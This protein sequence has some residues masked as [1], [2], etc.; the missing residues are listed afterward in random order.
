[1]SKLHDDPTRTTA[2]GMAR[3]GYEFLGAAFAVDNS[4]GNKNG[5][6]VITPIP[7][8]YLVGHGIELSLKAYML[9]HK[10]TL[11][12]LKGLGHNL[13]SCFDRAKKLGL[14]EIV[15]FDEQ[16]VSA[17]QILDELYST[18]QLEYI[19]TGAKQFPMFGPLQLFGVK[20]FNAVANSVSY[21]ERFYGFIE[22]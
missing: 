15:S 5:H 1:M 14:L 22:A 11:G 7:V 8:L 20:L 19:V 17:F 4:V 10:L 12:E 18:K 2:L 3:Y 6:E 13:S 9:Q 21:R 16:Q